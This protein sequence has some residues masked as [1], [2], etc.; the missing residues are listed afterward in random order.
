MYRNREPLQAT[1]R[2]P[3]NRRDHQNRSYSD[4]VKQGLDPHDERSPHG[5]SLRI[6]RM[7]SQKQGETREYERKKRHSPERTQS[8]RDTGTI[9][10]HHQNPRSKFD[11]IREQRRNGKK[12]RHHED[13]TRLTQIKERMPEE[14]QTAQASSPS[15]FW[16]GPIQE[17]L[18]WRENPPSWESPG[19]RQRSTD[20]ETEEE[21]IRNKEKRGK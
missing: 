7:P 17:R 20:Y 12:Y 4:V 8:Y 10:N 14:P 1:Y 11:P 15:V 16:R 2:H 19:K 5:S 3:H 13:T 21:E 18:K 9:E 6:R